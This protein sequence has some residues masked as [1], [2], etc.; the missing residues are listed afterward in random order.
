MGH[1]KGDPA[2]KAGPDEVWK[3]A[4][5]LWKARR[6]ADGKRKGLGKGKGK[7]NGKGGG[8]GNG[9]RK[10]KPYQRNLGDRKPAGDGDE[11]KEGICHNWSRGNGYCE[12]GPNCNYRH[13]GPQ[14]GKKR[15]ADA[16]TLLTSGGTKKSRK[17][18]VSLLMKDLKESLN[19]ENDAKRG[20]DEGSE[21]EDAHV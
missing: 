9:K 2:C 10:G 6:G 8:K 13:E 5:P 12:Y 19:G 21:D 4:P 18:L 20:R 14:G 1:L 7:S 16:A 3:G 17:K 15:N 11:K